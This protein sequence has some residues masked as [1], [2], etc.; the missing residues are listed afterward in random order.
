MISHENVFRG[1]WC[2]DSETSDEVLVDLDTNKIIAKRVAGK[3]TDP[4]IKPEESKTEAP[5]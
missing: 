4:D 1:V 3:I 5:T 2:R